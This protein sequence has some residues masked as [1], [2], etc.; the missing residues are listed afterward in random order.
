MIRRPPRST[1]FPYTTLFRSEAG[2]ELST[3]D[4]VDDDE[5]AEDGDADERLADQAMAP[6]DVALRG[7]LE[8]PVEDCEKARQRPAAR[9]PRAEQQSRQ[10][11]RQRQSVECRDEDR[12]RDGHRELG[13]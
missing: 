8:H 4:A 11:G 1:L 5:T 12:D 2:G 9:A 13:G 6:L 3:H 10:R 7:P